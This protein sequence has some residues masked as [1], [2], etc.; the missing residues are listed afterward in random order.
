[1]VTIIKTPQQGRCTLSK[2]TVLLL[3][4]IFVAV[5]C[6]HWFSLIISLGDAIVMGDVDRGM[7]KL[8][9]QNQQTEHQEVPLSKI[10]GIQ[11]PDVIP[12]VANQSTNKSTDQIQRLL[13][14]QTQPILQQLSQLSQLIPIS[15][16]QDKESKFLTAIRKECIP[17]RDDKK[18][19]INPT[20]HRNRE[21]LRHVPLGKQHPQDGIELEQRMK[22]QKPRI[23]IMMTPGYISKGIGMWIKHALEN[24]MKLSGMEI[25]ILF[26]SQVPVYGY[27]KSHGFT[28]LI[29]VV[30]LPLPLAVGDFYLYSVNAMQ[31][32][33]GRENGD[34]LEMIDKDAIQNT[35]PPTASVINRYLQLILRW[36]CRLSHVSAHT[37]MFTLS[38]ED[39]L[40]DPIDMLDRILQFVWREDWEWEGGN[41]KA[42]SGKKLWKQTAIDLVGAELDNKGSS[43]QSLLE[44]VSEILPAVSNAGQNNDLI[45]AIQSSFANEMKLSKD[46]TAWPCPSFW[47]GENDND[48]YFANALVPNCKED[49]PFVRC[50]VNRDRCEVRG[51]PKCK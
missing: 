6:F 35:A 2:R 47:E 14:Q 13:V 49:D 33:E 40:K 42:G 46:M 5:V 9:S 36:H 21:C 25:E 37:S 7:P 11:Q 26:T 20:T 10:K 41:K 17:G 3:L 44:H 30:V 16:E 29:R 4:L 19:D 22:Q 18:G 45:T 27:G 1:M 38:L 8:R 50:T 31:A 48:K 12:E 34:S 51:D 15:K 24:T 23:G 39:V 28:K 43:L 32:N